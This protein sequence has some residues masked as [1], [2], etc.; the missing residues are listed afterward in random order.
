MTSYALKFI[1]EAL[2]HPTFK[3]YETLKPCPFPST[4]ILMSMKLL[5]RLKMFCPEIQSWA[6]P[7]YDLSLFYSHEASLSQVLLT[8]DLWEGTFE[9]VSCC[10]SSAY[11]HVSLA[12]SWGRWQPPANRLVP[13]SSGLSEP[14]LSSFLPHL[15]Q[16]LNQVLFWSYEKNPKTFSPLTLVFLGFAG[17]QVFDI[18]PSTLSSY[19][20]NFPKSCFPR[21][22]KGLL[23]ELFW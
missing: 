16:E 19:R 1:Q 4:C 2:F 23:F 9:T 6:P 14:I 5:L 20:D 10:Y 17:T 22:P 11:L 12:H 7:S 18:F 21:C 13:R 15:S 8:K 3:S